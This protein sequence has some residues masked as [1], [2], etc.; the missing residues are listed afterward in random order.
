MRKL[1]DKLRTVIKY[2]CQHCVYITD[3]YLQ[4]LCMQSLVANGQ[5]ETL[6]VSQ[7]KK[8]CKRTSLSR[9]GTKADLVQRI[10][11]MLRR[12]HLI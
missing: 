12:Q 3:T 11:D 7:L 5:L 6:T 2:M 9:T 4:C 8:C 10:Q 1:H